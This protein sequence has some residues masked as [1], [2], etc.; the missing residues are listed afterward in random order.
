MEKVKQVFKEFSVK[1]EVVNV[2][3]YG[4]GHINKTYFI[5]TTKR[6]YILQCINTYA[7]PNVE[8]L[9]NNIIRVTSHLLDKEIFTIK[10]IPT[11][12]GKL[13]ATDSEYYYRV[14]KYIDNV[15]THEGLKDLEIVKKAAAGFGDFH[16]HLKDLDSSLLGE[17]IPNFHDTR[18]RYLN[19][20][21]AV[22]KDIIHRLSNCT[23]EVR[24]VGGLH[25]Y[26]GLICDE[27]D[28]GTIPT[29]ITH[30]DPKINNVLF[31]EA[32]D[33]IKCVIDLDTVM[34]GSILFDVGDALRSLFTG[35]NEDNTDPT[36]CHVDLGIYRAYLE[37][38]LSKM[39]DSLNKREIEL[40]PYAPLILSIECGMRFLED[41]LKG[42][43]YFSVKKKEHNLIRARTQIYL[44]YDILNNIEK[45]KEITNE[46]VGD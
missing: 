27:L 1:G 11:F 34:P 10:F 13:Y 25:E 31:D 29:N 3:P 45:L 32:T 24:K 33:D 46:I 36:T 14:Y 26:F 12:K 41:Y 4:N 35:E 44:A 40:L 2:Q 17:V 19:F 15:V 21:K 43:V 20:L 16:C 30:N 23:E 28:A 6:K 9:M 18:K 39:K 5:E 22:D 37:G 38:Y 42:D 7:F 8:L